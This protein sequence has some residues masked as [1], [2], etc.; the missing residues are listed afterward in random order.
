MEAFKQ[1]EWHQVSSV[2]LSRH[3]LKEGEA[4][5]S[6]NSMDGMIMMMCQAGRREVASSHWFNTLLP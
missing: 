3:N 4:E 6:L 5:S 2:N 1:E